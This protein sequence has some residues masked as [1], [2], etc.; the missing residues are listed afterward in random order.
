MKR[1]KERSLI[2]RTAFLLS[3]IVATISISAVSFL[4]YQLLNEAKQSTKSSAVA[5]TKSYAQN[6]KTLLARA[7]TIADTFG[8]YMLFARKYDLTREQI[9]EHMHDLLDHNKQLLGIYTLW[10]PNA[11]DGKDAMYVNDVR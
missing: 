2:F 8:R 7:E 10:E 11:F 5:E 9:L 6:I 1:W 4:F 3:I